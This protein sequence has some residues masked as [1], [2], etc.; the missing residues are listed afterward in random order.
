[1]EALKEFV[2]QQV[3]VMT[4]D[5]RVMVVRAAAVNADS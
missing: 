2:D 1:M 3:T 4:I 5:G